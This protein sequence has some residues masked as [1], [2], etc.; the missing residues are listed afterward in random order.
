MTPEERQ[1]LISGVKHSMFWDMTIAAIFE[2]LD[3]IL[4]PSLMNLDDT[5]LAGV[6]MK[7]APHLL[8]KD[9]GE[10]SD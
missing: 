4:T 5:E 9:D 10:S 8:E 6:V 3:E 2:L 7:Y 1:E